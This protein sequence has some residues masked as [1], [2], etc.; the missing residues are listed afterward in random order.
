[1]EPN[2]KSNIWWDCHF[3]MASPQVLRQSENILQVTLTQLLLVWAVTGATGD[4]DDTSRNPYSYSYN[5]ADS[6]TANHFQVIICHN[7]L[8]YQIPW[9]LH[10]PILLKFAENSD[11]G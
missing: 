9:P 2:L 4:Y 6:E 5:V 1:M 3:R 10:G 11:H 7:L 8:E